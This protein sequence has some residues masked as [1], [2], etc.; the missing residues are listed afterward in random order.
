LKSSAA[1]V[2]SDVP[3]GVRNR[4]IGYAVALK[5]PATIAKGDV[6]TGQVVGDSKIDR[7]PTCQEEHQKEQNSGHR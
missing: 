3:A 4:Q 2:C 5:S 1:I 7:V 6:P